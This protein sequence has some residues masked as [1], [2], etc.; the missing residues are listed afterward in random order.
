MPILMPTRTGRWSQAPFS[1]PALA[2]PRLRHE[3]EARGKPRWAVAG[4]ARRAAFTPCSWEVSPD[5]PGSQGR[6][7]APT[8]L[9]L[10]HRPCLHLHLVFRGEELRVKIPLISNQRDHR[11]IRRRRGW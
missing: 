3:K 1:C 7:C 4:V 6:A 5:G 8:P 9:R 2:P 10:S 11:L